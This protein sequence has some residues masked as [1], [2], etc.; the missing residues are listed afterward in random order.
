MFHPW[1]PLHLQGSGFFYIV[2]MYND[3][4][5]LSTA[6]FLNILFICTATT[7]LPDNNL[8]TLDTAPDIFT[9]IQGKEAKPHTAGPFIQFRCVGNNTNNCTFSQRGSNC[10][11]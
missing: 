6:D 2:V 11:C 3:V 8:V 9:Y 5:L 10:S 1:T 7:C 4:I